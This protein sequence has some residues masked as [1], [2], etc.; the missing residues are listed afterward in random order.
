[1]DGVL[2]AAAANRETMVTGGSVGFMVPA[3]N[4]MNYHAAGASKFL[5]SSCPM[6]DLKMGRPCQE[7]L[8][9]WR[10]PAVSAPTCA[11]PPLRPVRFCL[12]VL[13]RDPFKLLLWIIGWAR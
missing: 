3:D 5:T 11:A 13:L 4:L 1:M 10:Q 8:D 6:T 9:V 7:L 12:P 2:G